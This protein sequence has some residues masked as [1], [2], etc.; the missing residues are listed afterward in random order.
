METVFLPDGAL[1][2]SSYSPPPIAVRRASP[3]DTAALVDFLL[4]LSERT[5]A[6]RYFTARPFSLARAW[7]EAERMADGRGR[8]VTT[9]ATVPG[10]IGDEII[11]VG[12][13]VPDRQEPAV[14]HLGIAV[15]D[16][17]QGRGVGTAIVR[18]LRAAA[19][20]S[21][22]TTLRA[23]LLAENRAARRLIDRLGLPYTARTTAGE[24]TLLVPLP[25]PAQR[26]T[27]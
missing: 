20:G 7:Q 5:R 24:S 9:V 3:D 11:G 1:S 10:T 14:G 27:P 25:S 15:R 17:Q 18:S 8:A 4:R 26:P 19:A 6:R 16:D 22:F 23:D 2:S 13:L 12:E 21:G